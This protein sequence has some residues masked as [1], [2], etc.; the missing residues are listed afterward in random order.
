MFIILSLSQY[1]LLYLVLVI[2]FFMQKCG[3]LVFLIEKVSSSGFGGVPRVNISNK[4]VAAKEAHRDA[5]CQSLIFCWPLL[6]P[7]C[8]LYLYSAT[9]PGN[10]EICHWA[11]G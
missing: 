10:C 2:W 7:K 9:S 1:I 8:N 3:P 6:D 4:Q 11:V 5:R